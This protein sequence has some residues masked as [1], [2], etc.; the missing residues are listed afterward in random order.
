MIKK[1][2]SMI[3]NKIAAGEV[4]ERPAAVVKEL[5][6]NAIDAGATYVT[7]EIAQ[8]GKSLIRVSDNGHGISKND[9]TLAFERHAT[10]KISVVEDIYQISTLGFRGEA[11]ASIAS[12]SRVECITKTQ[13]DEMGTKF[14]LQGGVETY[15]ESIGTTVG[16]TLI[17]RDLFY[18]TPVRYKFLKSNQA[19]QSAIVDLVNKI[20]IA[21][22]AVKITLIVEGRELYRTD[23]R[24]KLLNTL[25]TIYGRQFIEQLI[26]INVSEAEFTIKGYISKPSYT[27]GNR[28]YQMLFV[29]GRYVKSEEL[30]KTI[31]NAYKGLV[32]IGQFPVFALNVFLP[33]DQVDVN[34]HPSKTE[35]RFKELI[36]I[37]GFIFTAIKQALM[38]IDL[39]P[40]STFDFVQK[41]Y[42]T[43]P[44]PIEKTNFNTNIP[45]MPKAA[46]LNRLDYDYSKATALE[47][48]N[49]KQEQIP[50]KNQEGMNPY[51]VDF[52]RSGVLEDSEQIELSVEQKD[53]DTLYDDL[54][55]IGQLF[56]T[57]IVCQRGQS[58]YFIDQ[59]AAHERILFEQFRESFLN[60]KIES[61]L[62]F[63]PFVYSS[64]ASQFANQ[65]KGISWLRSLGVEIELF[66]NQEWVIR[67][68]P[69]IHNE[70][71]NEL[72]VR[73]M[74]DAFGEYDETILLETFIED[75]IRKSCKAAI[76]A[77]Y[78]MSQI[79]IE[80]LFNHLKGLE[81]PYTCP[82][83]RPIIVEISQRELEKKFKRT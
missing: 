27:R 15:R 59:H 54:I 11:L 61:Q 56:F 48:A 40:K 77:N 74:L 14:I 57:Y 26:P 38:A 29:N 4:V 21:N 6:E 70:P 68:V 41:T 50:P 72:A 80:D 60:N 42:I 49:Y 46:L 45:S 64:E 83:G 32:T 10:S 58:A 55:V 67:T 7:V 19:E 44:I 79:E 34:I 8:A 76:K 1:L 25:L 5:I 12:V 52:F 3:S 65:Q 22:D 37:E 71:M 23:G 75:V 81:N 35:I 73:A 31:Y 28:S 24:G 47:S 30:Q 39:V 36:S 78:T 69:I 33:Y 20:A 53:K 43:E 62:L 9:L 18:N 17:I 66:G 16:T 63:T 82:H 2:D 51:L 13:E